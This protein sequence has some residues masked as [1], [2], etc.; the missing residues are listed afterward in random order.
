MHFALEQAPRQISS[1]FWG[2]ISI[3]SVSAH[4]LVDA[5]PEERRVR[6]SG[7]MFGRKRQSPKSTLLSPDLVQLIAISSIEVTSK[8]DVARARWGVGTADRWSADLA[9]GEITFHFPDRSIT[10]PV[11]VLGTWSRESETWLWG[12]ANE[13]LPP[14]VT[15]ASAVTREYG[16]THGLQALNEAKLGASAELSD[17]LAS[18]SVELGELAG[19]YRA[20]SQTGFIW[21][22]FTDFEKD[23]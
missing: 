15:Q 1:E 12:W 5:D 19:M 3:V 11:Q 7:P 17:D 23:E 6:Y 10:G 22:G 13:S 21:L 16:K 8:N 20:P 14:S 18:V 2:L 4:V 9:Q